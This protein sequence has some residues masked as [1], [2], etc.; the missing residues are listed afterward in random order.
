MA[1]LIIL[2]V[3]QLA[4]D[5]LPFGAVRLTFDPAAD[6]VAVLA[7]RQLHA[8]ENVRLREH[9]FVNDGGALRNQPRDESANPSSTDYF[10]N[11]TK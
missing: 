3:L 2:I 4:Q 6:R 10:F 7:R 8:D 9:V 5:A 1:Y 11:T